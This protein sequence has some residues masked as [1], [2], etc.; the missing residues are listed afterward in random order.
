LQAELD[1][2]RV[3]LRA[4]EERAAAIES[5]LPSALDRAETLQSERSLL[6]HRCSELEASNEKLQDDL[7][8]ISSELEEKVR[9]MALLTEAMASVEKE[10][11]RCGED[12]GEWERKHAALGVRMAEQANELRAEMEG[13]QGKHTAL[14]LL[15]SQRGEELTQKQAEINELANASIPVADQD[16]STDRLEEVQQELQATRKA[17][18]EAEASAAKMRADAEESCNKWEQAHGEAERRCSELEAL[19]SV[20]KDDN[21]EKQQVL[22]QDLL[23]LKTALEESESKWK[24]MEAAEQ[25]RVCLVEQEL[26]RLEAVAAA[27]AAVRSQDSA[28]TSV[29][30]QRTG[31]A[32]LLSWSEQDKDKTFDARH[33]VQGGREGEGGEEGR[34]APGSVAAWQA[35]PAQGSGSEIILLQKEERNE[36][37]DEAHKLRQALE[38]LEASRLSLEQELREQKQLVAQLNIDIAGTA[39]KLQEAQ[40]ACAKAEGERDAAHSAS[41]AL[42]VELEQAQRQGVGAQRNSASPQLSPAAKALNEEVQAART[43]RLGALQTQAQIA[44]ETVESSTNRPGLAPSHAALPAEMLQLRHEV[45]GVCCT[46]GCTW[47][48]VLAVAGFVA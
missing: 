33:L 37:R 22:R 17:V 30:K 32:A 6:A 13:W 18:Q 46:V 16:T 3:D 43:W 19:A 9:E 24:H 7:R 1:E 34:D 39:R 26:S 31:M 20:L 27:P 2:A 14:E 15:L 12:A 41:R 44:D 29:E 4:A 10:K 42:R 47:R 48:R 8:S 23:N 36:A 11:L 21:A 40:D 25:A 35:A 38:T 28:G 45:S 5:E